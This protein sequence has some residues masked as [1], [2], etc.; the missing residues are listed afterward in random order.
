MLYAP[1]MNEFFYRLTPERVLEAVE[2]AG[3]EPTGH[4]QALNSLENRVYDVRLED[5]SH[6]VAKFYRPAR[7]S[8]EQIREEH[9]FLFNLQA[10]EIPVCAPIKLSGDD[11]LGTVEDIFYAIW[12]RT[13]GRSPDEFNDEELE[14]LGRLV[15]RIHNV[16]ASRPAEYRRELSVQTYA[17]EPLEFLERRELLPEYLRGRYRQ[18]V[19]EIVEVYRA[20]SEGIPFHRIHGDCHTG[21]LLRGSE[22]FFFL[23]FDDFLTGPAVQDIWMLVS[24]GDQE[25]LRRRQVFLGGYRQIREFEDH[26]LK[27]IEP[28]RALRYVHYN[29]WVARRWEDPRLSPRLSSFWDRRGLGRGHAGSR[30]TNSIIRRLRI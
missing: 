22:G 26:W 19:E 24:A 13:G 6:T 3:F 21:N 11:S 12:P 27:L 9:E 2:A 1:V 28:L 4:C 25:G 29:A 15:A 23:D 17:L 14:M 20:W 7:W 18:A 5:G 16:G 8:E 30:R 10:D